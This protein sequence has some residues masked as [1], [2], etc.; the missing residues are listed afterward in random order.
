MERAKL[1]GFVIGALMN[2]VAEPMR[3]EMERSFISKVSYVAKSKNGFGWLGI[4]RKPFQLCE[5]K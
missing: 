1:A 5:A 2:A 4:R 3:R